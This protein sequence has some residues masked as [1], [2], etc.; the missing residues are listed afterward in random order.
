VELVPSPKFHAQLVGDPV[1]VSVNVAVNGVRPD[2]ESTVNDAT[3]AGVTAPPP[4]PGGG[5]GGGVTTGAVTVTV[6]RDSRKPAVYCAT[7]RTTYDPAAE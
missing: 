3:G 4:P 2:V 7:R 6:L 1:E 5:G